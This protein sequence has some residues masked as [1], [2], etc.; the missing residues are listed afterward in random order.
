[1]SGSLRE[2]G[3]AC[4][5]VHLTRRE[6]DVLLLAAADHSD[7]EIAAV[8]CLS[9]RTVETHMANMLDKAHV[10]SR[11]GLVARCFGVGVLQPGVAP[12]EWSG[13]TCLPQP[14]ARRVA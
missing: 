3:C 11:A 2:C 4:E 7:A 14:S 5:D 13:R 9:V 8:L 12:P 1:M 6:V 10:R